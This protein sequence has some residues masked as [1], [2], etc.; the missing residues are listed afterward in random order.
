MNNLFAALAISCLSGLSSVTY[1]Q[2]HSYS[3]QPEPDEPI[4]LSHM[5]LDSVSAA[6]KLITVSDVDATNN[7]VHVIVCPG[8]VCARTS[9]TVSASVSEAGV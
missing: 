1:A 5:E 8:A 7:Q 4:V 2:E 3:G 6:G 9:I